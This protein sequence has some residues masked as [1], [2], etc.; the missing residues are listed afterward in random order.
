MVAGIRC[1]PVCQYRNWTK[2]SEI[3]ARCHKLEVSGELLKASKSDQN[4]L[5][6]S[7][8]Q[9]SQLYPLDQR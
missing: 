4:I 3:N 5:F 9:S 6:D 7:Y 1:S 8:P 2:A